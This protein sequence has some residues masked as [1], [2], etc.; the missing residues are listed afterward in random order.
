MNITINEDF[1]PYYTHYHIDSKLYP[2][3]TIFKV[4]LNDGWKIKSPKQLKT[5]PAHSRTSNIIIEKDGCIIYVD[6]INPMAFDMKI[7]YGY[8][9][10]IRLID[11]ENGNKLFNLFG[12]I[13]VGKSNTKEVIRLWGEPHEKAVFKTS[14]GRK[15]EYFLYQYNEYISI[16]YFDKNENKLLS[17]NKVIK[18][19]RRGIVAKFELCTAETHFF[20]IKEENLA[21]HVKRYTKA[22][23]FLRDKEFRDYYSKHPKSA[24]HIKALNNTYY[25]NLEEQ[26][27]IL[28]ETTSE[29]YKIL[30]SNNLVA[31][32]SI[33]Y[34]AIPFV[35]RKDGNNLLD[36]MK[37]LNEGNTIMNLIKDIPNS[38][39]ISITNSFNDEIGVAHAKEIGTNIVI[40]YAHC[41]S[42]LYSFSIRFYKTILPKIHKMKLDNKN[43]KLIN[44]NIGGITGILIYDDTNEYFIKTINEFSKTYNDSEMDEIYSIKDIVQEAIEINKVNFR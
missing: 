33:Q 15:I 1:A 36:L 2:I 30:R 4:F 8:T 17:L 14:L 13:V 42:T 40:T 11:N 22:M 12:G 41:Y 29:S 24:R 35:N 28:G 7:Q 31:S 25:K 5:L 26:N 6:L 38:Y 20:E 9:V 19:W 21:W 18:K 43:S 34:K 37:G 3:C 27:I 44:L 23:K 10:S 39:Y 32:A 16:F